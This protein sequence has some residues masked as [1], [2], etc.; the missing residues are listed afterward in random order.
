MHTCVNKNIC[1]RMF[2]AA[3]F[4]IVPKRKLKISIN[5]RINNHGKIHKMEYSN[6]NIQTTTTRND[7]VEFHKC[8]L[9]QSGQ[10]KG[11]LIFVFL[12]ISKI[13]KADL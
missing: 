13:A 6:E 9:R 11:T 3:L 2:T 12:L 4:I 10:R 5:S 8:N 1:K 7:M